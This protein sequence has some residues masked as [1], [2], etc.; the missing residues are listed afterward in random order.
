MSQAKVQQLY[1]LDRLLQE[2]SGTLH[3]LQQDKVSINICVI[4]ADT[5]F[6]TFKG[7]LR[8]IPNFENKIHIS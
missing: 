5:I 2:E 1:K 8:R 4:A 3:S 6:L 7:L